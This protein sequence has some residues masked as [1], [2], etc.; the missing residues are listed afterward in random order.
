MIDPNAAPENPGR[1]AHIAFIS[2]L[3]S[4]IHIEKD[5]ALRFR[6]LQDRRATL[7]STLQLA[8]QAAVNAAHEVGAEIDAETRNLWQETLNAHGVDADD[9]G[10]SIDAGD[11]E[12]AYLMK[13]SELNEAQNPTTPP[14]P[15]T[16]LALDPAAIKAIKEDLDA[17][18]GRESTLS[19]LQAV[20]D[21]HFGQGAR[22]LSSG[23]EQVF[24]AD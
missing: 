6:S 3:P 14:M 10:W 2:S 15:V 7:E 22:V 12:R 5:H 17:K 13:M 18:L 16:S 23:V 4:S 20:L 9:I 1:E 21:E 19:E 8:I 11:P 24:S